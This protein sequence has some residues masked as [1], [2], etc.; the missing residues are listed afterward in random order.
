MVLD[1]LVLGAKF[2]YLYTEEEQDD[3][4][5]SGS[6]VS[7]VAGTLRFVDERHI[8][9]S[10]IIVGGEI[11]YT[12]GSFEPYGIATYHNDLDRD[13]GEDAGG[14]PGNF[15]SVQPDDDDEVQV[16]GGI[17]YYTD[18][19]LTTSIEY[20]RVEGREDFDS[21]TVMVIIR[22]AL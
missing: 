20:M 16:G 4:T 9:L 15:T 12:L 8:D 3:Y 14:L 11:A 1:N 10:Q 18:W 21:Q 7:A 6:A 13:D 17:R 5:E 2:G 19:G 22:A